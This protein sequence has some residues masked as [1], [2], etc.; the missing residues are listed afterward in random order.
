MEAGL[1]KPAE[2]LPLV[3]KEFKRASEAGGAFAMASRSVTAEQNRLANAWADTVKIFQESLL[4]D[5]IAET[6]RGLGAVLRNLAPVFEVLG[7]ALGIVAKSFGY[8]LQVI[9]PLTPL[10]S[11]FVGMFAATR[12]MRMAG[13]FLLFSTN[14]T[15]VAGAIRAVRIAMLALIRN[16][17]ILATLAAIEGL[18]YLT[19]GKTASAHAA[20][21]L[22]GTEQVA[23]VQQV[24]NYEIY[25]NNSNSIADEIAAT[26]RSRR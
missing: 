12:I 16:P 19:T 14:L 17:A 2:V 5:G 11:M 23:P 21:A 13:A 24:N 22:F 20:D 15:K 26:Q 1:L 8:L 10:L 7:F 18:T 9:A 6:F 25:G 3:A 4:W